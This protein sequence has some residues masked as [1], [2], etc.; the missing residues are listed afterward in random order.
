MVQRGLIYDIGFTY[1]QLSVE[2]ILLAL[3][4]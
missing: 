3:L 4:R 1:N 2:R